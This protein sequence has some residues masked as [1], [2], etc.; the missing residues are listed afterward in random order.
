MTRSLPT[1]W[2]GRAAALAIAA[3]ALAAIGIGVIAPM[4]ALYAERTARIDQRARLASHMARVAAGLPNLR[5]AAARR[6]DGPATLIA[7]ASDAVAA[8]TLQTI[9]QSAAQR[10]GI[11]LTAIETTQPVE[12]G[13]YRRIGLNLSGAAS[14]PA[15][16][17][18]LIDLERTEAPRLAIGALEIRRADIGD[19][20]GG[21]SASLAVYAFR[22][23][24]ADGVTR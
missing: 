4:T 21:L 20:R 18:F 15:L 3:A 13:P 10:D 24:A 14:W 1:G 5:V 22:A 9:V 6:T 8:A 17:Q 16:V 2:R 23:A 12:A 7:G 19:S 11:A